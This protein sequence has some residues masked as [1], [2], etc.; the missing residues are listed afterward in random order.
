MS[1]DKY[2]SCANR[3]KTQDPSIIGLS[4]KNQSQKILINSILSHEKHV[5]KYG[6]SSVKK[7]KF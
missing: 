6:F 7:L 3:L 1:N 5:M 4:L 2:I